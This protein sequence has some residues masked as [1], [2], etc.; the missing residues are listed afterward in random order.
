MRVSIN[1]MSLTD[2]SFDLN[3]VSCK[4]SLVL[5]VLL[6]LERNI[7]VDYDTSHKQKRTFVLDSE[8]RYLIYLTP[9]LLTFL[10]KAIR[11]NIN[12]FS[13]D[14]DKKCLKC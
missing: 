7:N 9:E 6:I 1:S 2:L 4:G 12:R 10:F 8:R 5:T 11:F 13:F 3:P 14:N